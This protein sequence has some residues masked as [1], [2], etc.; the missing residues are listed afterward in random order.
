[1][2][3]L[4]SKERSVVRKI[5]DFHVHP[6]YEKTEQT[7]FY[8]EKFDFDRDYFRHDIESAG[9]SGI[10]GSVID[11][12]GIK[13]E[14]GFEAFRRLN[15]NALKLR[16]EW[17]DFYIPG[18]HVHPSFVKESCEELQ[19]MKN[20]GVR[21]VGELVPYI[22]DWLDYSCK[23]FGEILDV[24]GELG[25]IVSFHS[26]DNDQMEA[27]IKNHPKVTFVAAHPGEKEDYLLHLERLH[28]YPNAYLDLSGTGLFRYGMLKYGVETVGAEKFLFGTD[29]PITNP[30]MYVQ[31]VEF[32]KISERDKELI[33][34][35][36]AERLL[37]HI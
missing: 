27:M 21:L 33:F 35:K 4:E 1:M 31:A 6:F 18:V 12:K 5:I 14:D 15:R 25:M 36:N 10:C 34:Y 16:E 11:F 9:I 3:A 24:I 7:C 26:L 37:G 8:R 19:Y 17:G 22:H 13:V 29:Y 28:K 20:Q 2:I 23:S 32:E 30:Y